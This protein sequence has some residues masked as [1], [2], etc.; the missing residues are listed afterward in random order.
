MEEESHVLDGGFAIVRV[1]VEFVE[2]ANEVVCLCDVGRNVAEGGDEA[3]LPSEPVKGLSSS[4]GEGLTV[5]L[6]P[7]DDVTHL[8]VLL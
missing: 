8:P 4:H 6:G 5:S 7:G 1:R 3:F 2:A